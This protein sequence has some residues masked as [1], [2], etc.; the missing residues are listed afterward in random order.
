MIG[1][2]IQCQSTI[3]SHQSTIP[4]QS[5]REK[6]TIP[7]L[8][9]RVQDIPDLCRFFVD[10]FK[11]KLGLKLPDSEVI[12]LMEYN[13]PGNVRELKN[14]IERSIILR[15]GSS[16]RPAAL[17]AEQRSNT[18]GSISGDIENG[19]VS[20]LKDMEK[21]HIEYA[22]GEL[23]YNL[24]KTARKIGV[25]RSTLKRKID[26]YGLNASVLK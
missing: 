26:V 15:R 17:I 5:R 11:Q 16:L 6:L 21:K 13:W 25:S 19:K 20:T 24:S 22:L 2:T 8:R 14:I 9:Q 3:N 4:R 18:L 7:P 10:Q 12:A 1:K 23:S